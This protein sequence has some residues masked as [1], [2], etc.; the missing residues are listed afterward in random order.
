MAFFA[1]IATLSKL[2]PKRAVTGTRFR[3]FEYPLKPNR[4]FER[5]YVDQNGGMRYDKC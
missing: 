2:F 5:Q 1:N 3:R 4:K